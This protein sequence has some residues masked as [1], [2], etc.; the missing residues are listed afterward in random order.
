MLK[1]WILEIRQ[2]IFQILLQYTC[3]PKKN[4]ANYLLTEIFQWP[5]F[6]CTK[7]E[8]KPL[9]PRSG[10]EQEGIDLH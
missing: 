4:Y 8:Q 1:F 6:T 10:A 2:L 5:N 9:I 3:L 7:Q